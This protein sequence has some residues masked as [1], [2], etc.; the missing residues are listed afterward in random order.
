VGAVNAVA[1]LLHEKARDY[2]L[3]AEQLREQE[4]WQGEVAA[5]DHL[6]I[7]VALLEVAHAL[8][9]EEAA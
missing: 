7:A 6:A 9:E 4:T 3:Q 5:C 1:E 8:H 2:E